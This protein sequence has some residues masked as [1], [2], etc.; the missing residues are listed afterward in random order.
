MPAVPDQEWS[1]EMESSFSST[2]G[3]MGRDKL[4]WTDQNQNR[5]M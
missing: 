2:G 5:F 1:K 4:E 3:E